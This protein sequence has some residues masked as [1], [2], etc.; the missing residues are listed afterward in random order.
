MSY[1]DVFV[2]PVPR[3]RLEEY[4]SMAALACRVWIEHGALEYREF[5]ADDV[6][7]GE[8]TSFPMSVRIQDDEIVGIGYARYVSREHR[9]EVT[10]KVMADE[11]MA[12]C[13]DPHKLPFDGKRLIWGGF[14]W[15][16]GSDD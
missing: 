10:R 3:S 6:P 15:L 4:R 1:I 2:L 14:K 8:V 7:N 5:L 9:D 11:R 13:M 12:D 16:I